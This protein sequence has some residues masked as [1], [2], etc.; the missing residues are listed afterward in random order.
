MERRIKTHNPP[1]TFEVFVT[2]P[3][4][5]RREER[6]IHPVRIRAHSVSDAA[7]VARNRGFLVAAIAHPR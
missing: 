3:D 7:E 2:D 4:A 6:R 1:A 5:D